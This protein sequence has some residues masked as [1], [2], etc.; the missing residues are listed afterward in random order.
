LKPHHVDAVILSFDTFEVLT[1]ANDNF[2]VVDGFEISHLDN[3]EELECVQ[4]GFRTR[5]VKGVT[6]AE[7]DFKFLRS[8]SN[9]ERDDIAGEKFDI[10]FWFDIKSKQK[11]MIHRDIMGAGGFQTK[12]WDSRSD[13]LKPS[14]M[15]PRAMKYCAVHNVR[16]IAKVA[17]IE[18]A[19]TG[20]SG[21]YINLTKISRVGPDGVAY[22]DNPPEIIP[23]DDVKAAWSVPLDSKSPRSDAANTQKPGW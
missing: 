2:N 10:S 22:G 18:N 9:P 5:D 11:I 4:T 14:I 20:K 21:T 8:V 16:F 7:L 3:G 23:N 17:K 15:I 13:D 19:E 6:V 12:T 1:M